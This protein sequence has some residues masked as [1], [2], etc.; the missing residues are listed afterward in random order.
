MLLVALH[1]DSS[2]ENVAN[3]IL[4]H[5][6]VA[7]SGHALNAGRLAVGDVLEE[8]GLPAVMAVVM[9]T[10]QRFVVFDKVSL[11]TDIAEQ[12]RWKTARQFLREVGVLGELGIA[13]LHE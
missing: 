13:K 7:P 6:S 5:Q 9:L 1:N 10:K 4:L 2:T 11:K 8:V 12:L 3:K